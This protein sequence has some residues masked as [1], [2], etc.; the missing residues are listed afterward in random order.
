[1]CGMCKWVLMLTETRGV[2]SPGTETTD[3]G[4]IINMG[5]WNWTWVLS[6][7]IAQS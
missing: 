1:M 6:K 7:S 3:N 5:A 4:R 2:R